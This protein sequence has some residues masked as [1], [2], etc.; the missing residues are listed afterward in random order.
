MSSVKTDFAASFVGRASSPSSPLAVRSTPTR[1]SSSRCAPSS[2][3]RK[4]SGHPSSQHARAILCPSKKG[5]ARTFSA[6]LPSSESKRCSVHLFYW[7]SHLRFSSLE[8]HVWPQLCYPT[9]L[10]RFYV[11]F[12]GAR[13]VRRPAASK[14][15]GHRARRSK[16]NAPQHAARMG[17]GG[18]DH[19]S[20]PAQPADRRQ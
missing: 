15:T 13:L 18:I 5:A 6:F 11:R 3:I 10:Q 9:F 4:N 8:V 12:A 20:R 7:R 14:Q 17:I 1:L 19:P 16:E 2:R